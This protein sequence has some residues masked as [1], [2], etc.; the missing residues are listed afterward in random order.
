VCNGYSDIGLVLISDHQ[1]DLWNKILT[2]KGL[3]FNLLKYVN[4]CACVSSNSPLY[5]CD[6]I[7]DINNILDYTLILYNADDKDC[8]YL[9]ERSQSQFDKFKHVINVSEREEVNKLLISKDSLCIGTD[10]NIKNM[11]NINNSGFKYKL[12][13]F[14]P[15]IKLK[16]GWIKLNSLKMTSI[17]QKFINILQK[18]II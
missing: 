17:Q 5:N 4:L 2:A 12:I 15:T 10:L 14:K 9:Y 3:E 13:P 18:Q 16:F 1:M 7:D 6:Y 8:L 11:L